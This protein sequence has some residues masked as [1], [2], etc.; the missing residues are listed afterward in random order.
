[1]EKERKEEQKDEKHDDFKLIK[2]ESRGFYLNFKKA[3]LL[4]LFGEVDH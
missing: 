2:T 3:V 1:M 4:F